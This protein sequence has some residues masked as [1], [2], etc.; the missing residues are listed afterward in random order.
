[1]ASCFDRQPDLKLG[2]S[3]QLEYWIIGA[4]EWWVYMNSIQF[5]TQYSDIPS[6]H[7]SMLHFNIEQQLKIKNINIL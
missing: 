1:M 2:A 4:L 3:P 7:Y 6:F 5:Y